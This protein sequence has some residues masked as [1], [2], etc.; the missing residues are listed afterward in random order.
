MS[1]S[2]TSGGRVGGGVKECCAGGDGEVTERVSADPDKGSLLALATVSL[3]CFSGMASLGVVLPVLPARLH[4]TQGYGLTMVG[5]VI[6]LES[7]STLLSRAWAGV[8]TDRHGGRRATIFGLAIMALSGVACLL[9]AGADLCGPVI[10]AA[11]G[12]A[13]ILASR[14][15]LGVGEGLL[16]AGSALW[17]ID[18]AGKAREGLAVSWNGLGMFAGMAVGSAIGAWIYQ[19]FHAGFLAASC[20]AVLIPMLGVLLAYPLRDTKIA[21][22]HVGASRDEIRIVIRAIIKPGLGLLANAMGFAALTSFLVLDYK[23]NGWGSLPWG[24]SGTG[25]AAFGAGHVFARLL[26]SNLS[27]RVRSP[28]PVTLCLLTEAFGLCGIW[29]SSGPGMA[30][31]MA[32][33][34]GFGFSM[35]YPFLSRPVLNSVPVHRRGL[36]LGLFDG[37]FDVGAGSAALCSGV[38]AQYLNLNVVFALVAVAVVAGLVPVFSISREAW[39]R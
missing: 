27:D 22:E 25:I 6:G 35:G 9:S 5:C 15:L 38:I 31:V 11:I 19:R 7:L 13:L 1:D 32:G 28:W 17:A 4:L 39:R 14:V 26:F 23:A 37:F 21:A 29:L 10:G 34:T 8:W 30:A 16:I 18:R 33:L 24:G 20:V 3:L 36:A 12:L 2:Q